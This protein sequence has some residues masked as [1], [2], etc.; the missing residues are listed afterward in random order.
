MMMGS[1]RE[2]TKNTMFDQWLDAV[3]AGSNSAGSEAGGAAGGQHH[4][5]QQQQPQGL[6]PDVAR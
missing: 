6:D 3:T 4:Q 1:L 2:A 5:Q